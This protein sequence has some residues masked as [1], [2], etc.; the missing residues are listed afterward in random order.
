MMACLPAM[1]SCW[2]AR[3]CAFGSAG[4]ERG[5]FAGGGG[6]GVGGCFVA[7]G[8]AAPVGREGN[9]G[10][11]PAVAAGCVFAGA[12]CA[13]AGAG[14]AFAGAGGPAVGWRRGLVCCVSGGRGDPGGVDG[15][16]EGS[17][18]VPAAAG[19][20][21]GVRGCGVAGDAASAGVFE[22]AGI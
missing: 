16:A 11:P 21:V 14:C 7:T 5:G 15:V 6:C 20:P 19:P 8:S 2:S 13:F 9:A 12:G 1:Y 4:T 22:V 3:A 18:T 17:T 10:W